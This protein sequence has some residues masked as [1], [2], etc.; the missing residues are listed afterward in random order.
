MPVVS[1]PGPWPLGVSSI[2]MRPRHRSAFAGPSQRMD[3][4]L[5]LL[6]GIGI[7]A[8]VGVRPMLPVLLAGALASAR[9][10]AW[11]STGTDF[12]FLES[13]PFLLAAALASAGLVVRRP[14]AGTIEP[15]AAR[16]RARR[17]R[18]WCWARSRPPARSPT[19]GYTIV[20]RRGRSAP[21]PRRSAS[22]PRATCSPACAAGSTPRRAARCPSTPRASRWPAP[23]LSI[24]FPPLALLV[25]GA[26]AWLLLGGRRREGEK[27]AGL[28]ILR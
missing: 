15:A 16:L 18:A 14:R 13:W 10:R 26:L 24:L 3:F 28:R 7:A 4:V 25:V 23:A 11:T 20:A 22:S 6:Q 12:A 27:Y 2:V 21:P 17:R 5:D 1:P 8:A 9:R 19:A